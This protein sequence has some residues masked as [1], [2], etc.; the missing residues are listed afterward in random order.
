MY[1]STELLIHRSI[2]RSL[3]E[4]YYIFNII[5]DN[6]NRIDSRTNSSDHRNIDPTVNSIF[7]I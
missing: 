3:Y 6:K 7:I 2:P 4:S 5:L 1:G